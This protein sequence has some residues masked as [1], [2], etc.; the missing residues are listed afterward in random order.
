MKTMT[1]NHVLWHSSDYSVVSPD[2]R[3]RTPQ[4]LACSDT[5]STLTPSEARSA[6]LTSSHAPRA[7]L[8]RHVLHPYP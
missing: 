1:Q 4:D 3:H 7:R 2:Q 8:L 5:S 6:S